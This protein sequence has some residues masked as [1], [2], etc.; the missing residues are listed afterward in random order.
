MSDGVLGAIR[1]ALVKSIALFWP[2][3]LLTLVA[4]AVIL[5]AHHLA[6]AV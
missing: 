6:V 4:F 3:A 5:L 1:R 2:A